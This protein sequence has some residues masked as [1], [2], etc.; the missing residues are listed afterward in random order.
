MKLKNLTIRTKLFLGFIIVIVVLTIIGLIGIY[1][2]DNVGKQLK[3]VNYNRLP[4]E[5]ELHIIKEGQ[6]AIKTS[7]RSLLIENYPVADFK[8]NEFKHIEANMKSIETAWNS[9]I[10]MKH[11][12]EEKS[13]WDTF[14]T[15][16]N[17][18]KKYHIEFMR[19]SKEEN[20]IDLL[21]KTNK[22][23]QL[24]A[25]RKDISSKIINASLEARPYFYKAEYDLDKLLKINKGIVDKLKV[26]GDRLIEAQTNLL[27][28]FIMGGIIL[29]LILCFLIS[30]N[31]RNIIKS[32][33]KQS[34]ELT[35]AAINGQL[36]TRA[37]AEDTDKEF[38]D[39]VIGFNSILNAITIPLN[40]AANC[41]EQI[42]NGK[43]PDKITSHYEGDYNIIINNLNHC[44]DGL[45]GLTEANI[46][47]QKMAVND[48][49][50]KMEGSYKGIFEEVAQS[51]NLVN[52]RITHVV[53]ML[54][55]ISIGIMDDL[56]DL[57]K[58]GKRSENDKLITSFIMLIKTLNQITEKAKLIAEGDLTVTLTKR[59]D[60][61]ELLG[62]LSEMVEKL[63]LIVA[64]I[65][66]SSS[67]VASASSQFS[68]TTVQIAQGA[69]EQASSAEEVSS[70]IEE[71]NST[72]QQNADNAAQTEKIAS[73][74][75][76]GMNEVNIASQKVLQATHQIADKI[77]IINAIAE[78]TDI[79]AINAAIEAARAG[80]H[81]KGFAVVAAEV[82]KLAETSQKAAIEINTLSNTSLKVTEESGSMMI[83]IIPDIQKTATLVQEIS[84]ASIEQSSG[85]VQITQA[86]EQLSQIIQKNSA[87][88]EEMSSTAEEL[89]SQAET[90]QEVI[91]FFNTGHKTNKTA[92]KKP[93]QNKNT[94]NNFKLNFSR[95]NGVNI[96]EG[97]SHD[98][99]F[100][101]Y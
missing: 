49:T 95:G 35:Y 46:V 90:L 38:R 48:Y 85:S 23:K 99:E 31:I 89:A 101:S 34:G 43:I 60:K 28:I 1:G 10:S 17:Q 40:T 70:S 14:A 4:N 61:D 91:S 87:A 39:I 92:A 81:G 21:M 42:S 86:I 16:W 6:S 80:E 64:Q 97:E 72:I 58:I 15:S 41:I 96:L 88:S 53:Q 45:G 19:L 36:S 83:K 66:E 11:T 5:D 20:D 75:A 62:A 54:E 27:I 67:N 69:N 3:E 24:T 82:R 50:R 22:G 30:N 13:A 71:M 7:E 77:K 65:M 29:A 51:I 18:W 73:N 78:K 2:F 63:N 25:E 47:L 79:L 44:I 93:I 74:T 9:Y 26:S 56:I 32:V 94:L 98:K 59:S 68:A 33:I 12:L 57:E 37:R 76:K 8:N 84:A 55:N 52:S 100:E